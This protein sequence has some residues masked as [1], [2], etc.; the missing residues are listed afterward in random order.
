MAL[1]RWGHDDLGLH[2]I[3]LQHSTVNE[4]S[5]RAATAAGFLPEGIRRGANLHDD[6]WHD[7]HL[8][9]HL[10]SDPYP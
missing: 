10:S 4:A 2:R 8:H 7:M 6:G 5:C 3:E 9:A 1:T